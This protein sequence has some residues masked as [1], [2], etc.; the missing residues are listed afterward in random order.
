MAALSTLGNSQQLFHDAQPWASICASQKRT[1]G[2]V[3]ER[4]SDTGIEEVLETLN[5]EDDHVL[6]LSAV[7]SIEPVEGLATLGRFCDSLH[8][9]IDSLERI[10]S[11]A[12][13]F[14]SRITLSVK[15]KIM[16]NGLDPD[17]IDLSGEISQLIQEFDTTI[18]IVFQA[19]LPIDCV[20]RS[21]LDTLRCSQTERPPTE[22]LNQSILK[23]GVIID[24]LTS[25]AGSGFRCL[26]L[27]TGLAAQR[28]VLLSTAT[29]SDQ[30][31]VESDGFPNLFSDRTQSLTAVVKT[32]NDLHRQ[33]MACRRT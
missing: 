31:P 6:P 17:K 11:V 28:R 14:T 10:E 21:I 32:A 33:F 24:M 30:S 5:L 4:V 2:E 1:F 26:L 15:L 12:I 13:P 25:L 19:A 29:S 22:E 18:S 23:L 27:L 20:L 8:R 3:T 9:H 7:R 16:G